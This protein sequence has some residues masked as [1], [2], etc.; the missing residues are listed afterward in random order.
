[1]HLGDGNASPNGTLSLRVRGKSFSR[2]PEVRTRHVARQKMRIQKSDSLPG[3]EKVENER[4][5]DGHAGGPGF[6]RF[7]F[8]FGGREGDIRP[9]PMREYGAH[10]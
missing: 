9:T 7:R 5:D 2:G 10:H 8:R 6:R 1:M 4:A 3:A